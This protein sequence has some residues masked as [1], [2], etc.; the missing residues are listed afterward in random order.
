MNYDN[1]DCVAIEDKRNK[2]ERFNEIVVKV[3]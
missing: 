2:I 3:I 1:G